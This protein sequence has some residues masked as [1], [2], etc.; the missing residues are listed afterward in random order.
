LPFGLLPFCVSEFID[1]KLPYFSWVPGGYCWFDLEIYKYIY[2]STMSTKGHNYHITAEG[3]AER[4]AKMQK[5]LAKLKEEE[6]N[7]DDKTK[8]AKLKE[9]EKDQKKYIRARKKDIKTEVSKMK[10]SCQRR[11][12]K[13]NKEMEKLDSKTKELK[14][15]KEEIKECERNIESEINYFD[16]EMLGHEEDLEET[17][18]EIRAFK[19]KK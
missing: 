4:V 16:R 11:T 1:E 10:K 8:L 6:E 19:N 13:Y 7:A 14:R 3:R 18:N 17:Q 5:R 12:K 15:E 2:Y 9:E